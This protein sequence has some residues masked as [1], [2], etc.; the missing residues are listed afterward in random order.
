[1]RHQTRNMSAHRAGEGRCDTI[2][3]VGGLRRFL[4]AE[5]ARDHELN[6]LLRC[7]TAANDR[8][9]DLGGRI[10]VNPE[11]VLL[12]G[13]ED[14]AACVAKYDGRA[15][16]SREEDI[17][18]GKGVGLV[19]LDQLGDAF[20]NVTKARGQGL[21]C[22]GS[23]NPTFHQSVGCP[24]GSTDYAVAGDGR[25]RIDPENDQL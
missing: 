12:A 15:N 17:L 3:C 7:A 4:Q 24:C 14:D 20:E 10:L 19:P 2:G 16:V 25:A 5:Q 9:L 8:F 18:D 6:L 23:D 21:A 11:A 13:K 1:M 22:P